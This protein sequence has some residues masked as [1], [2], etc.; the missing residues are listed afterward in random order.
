MTAW[1]PIGVGDTP[2]PGASTKTYAPKV[3][4]ILHETKDPQEAAAQVAEYLGG[5]ESLNGD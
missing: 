5:V 2:E 4:R 1:N 3:A